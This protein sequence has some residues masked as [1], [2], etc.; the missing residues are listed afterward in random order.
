MRFL[1]FF[2]SRFL[3]YILVVWIGITAVFF[4]PRFLPSNPVESMLGRLTN[5]SEF[6]TP[7]QI[8]ALRASLQEMYGLKG[9]LWEQYVGFLQRVLITGDFGPSFSSFPTPVSELVSRALPW[10][11]GLLICSTLISWVIGNTIGLIVGYRKDKLSS[12]ILETIAMIVYP[13]PYYILAL[14]LIIV[15]VVL[16]NV[17]GETRAA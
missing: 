16:L 7:D 9:T 8:A 13:M 11:I 6:M 15:G 5:R 2:A 4:I 10:T 3:T 14:V 1:Q 12:R 17:V